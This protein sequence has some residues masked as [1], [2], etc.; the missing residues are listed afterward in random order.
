MQD[1]MNVLLDHSFLNMGWEGQGLIDG[2]LEHVRYTAYPHILGSIHV[3]T[4]VRLE[5]TDMRFYRDIRL[6]PTEYFLD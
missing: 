5:E 2:Q 3:A 4:R 6:R 1:V